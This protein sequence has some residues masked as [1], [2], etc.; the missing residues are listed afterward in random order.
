MDSVKLMNRTEQKFMFHSSALPDLLNKL[1]RT[2][3]VL[4]VNNSLASTYKTLYFD[5]QAF[6]LYLSH[7]NGRLNRYKVRCRNYIESNTG[8]LEV[9]FRNNKGKVLKERIVQHEIP[10]QW[11]DSSL[12]FLSEKI[13][14]DP[15]QLAPSVWVNYQ[16]ITLV[17]RMFN[18]RVTIDMNL[19]FTKGKLNRKLENLVIAEVK[20]AVRLR[21]P[22]LDVL[23]QLRIK[24]GALS[25]YCL[26]VT[27]LCPHI[28]N[29]NFKEKLNSINKIIY[30]KSFSAPAGI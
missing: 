7:H 3:K 15:R 30:G 12:D 29:N 5:T 6:S 27:Q 22:V 17:N 2:Y 23:R 9:K 20:Q 8:F 14:D 10:L 21:T 25:K 28:K 4:Q 1:G 16:R 13:P 18:E 24:E 26:G 11:N 19:E